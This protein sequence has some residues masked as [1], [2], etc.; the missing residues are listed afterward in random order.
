M[1]LGIVD[2]GTL[3]LRFDV[4]QLGELTPIITYRSTPRLGD[5]IYTTGIFGEIGLLKIK[6]ELESVARLAKESNTEKIIAVGTSAF[7]DAQ[8]AEEIVK[9]VATETGITVKILSGEQEASLTARGI[10]SRESLLDEDVLLLDIGGGST[11]LT[12]FHSGKPEKSLSIDVGVSRLRAEME[13][14]SLESVG[15][16]F[17]T[18]GDRYCP[19]VLSATIAQL[20]LL[21]EKT[22]L[23]NISHLP[24]QIVGSSGTIR[25]LERINLG[26]SEN[27]RLITI[28]SL[29][30]ALP[31]L[32]HS[33]KAELLN[34]GG[35]EESRVDVLIPGFIILSA[36]LKILQPRE[37]IVSHYS[38]RHG[39]LDC[40][41]KGEWLL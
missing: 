41:E 1:K 39:V 9:L 15:S 29:D 36:L 20:D 38:L 7:R 8:D 22:E 6:S 13:Q 4:F 16:S 32:I 31:N 11:E 19:E 18:T 2:F 27:P 21:L 10:L 3:S 5:T 23:A 34:V 28:K 24:T 33:S 14:R 35:V 30:L 26:T 40:V 37:I 17:A 12:I 25:A